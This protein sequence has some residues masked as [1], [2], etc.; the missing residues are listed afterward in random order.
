MRRICACVISTSKF[1]EMHASV[2]V[3]LVST[4]Q[5]GLK[6]LLVMIDQKLPQA[7]KGKSA[8]LAAS[9]DDEPADDDE[10]DEENVAAV[11]ASGKFLLRNTLKMFCFLITVII[12]H[13]EK[14]CKATQVRGDDQISG[15]RD[16][17]IQACPEKQG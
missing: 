15:S 17:D 16:T 14:S 4:L 1:T 10:D 12:D 6:N 9:D 3:S 7:A 2:K 13:S 8:A 5:H 11:S